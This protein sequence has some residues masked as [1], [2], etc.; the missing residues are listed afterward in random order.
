M[1]EFPYERLSDHLSLF[2]SPLINIMTT[3]LHKQNKSYKV[4]EE[5]LSI[6]K[7]LFLFQ[8]RNDDIEILRWYWGIKKKFF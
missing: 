4:F 5:R 3:N 6:L 8:T 2:L 1:L 7:H